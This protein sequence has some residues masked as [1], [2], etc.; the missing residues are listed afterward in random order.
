[1]KL[2][3]SV[4]LGAWFLIGLN[5][6]MA[7]GSIWVFMRMAPAIEVI[8]DR[9]EQ[10]L[11]SCENM[12]SSLALLPPEASAD[13]A[14]QS[15]FAKALESA[16]SNIT[17][18]E[19]PVALESITRNYPKA[20]EGDFAARQRTVSAVIHLADINRRAMVKADRKARQFG[21][22]GAWGVVFMAAAVFLVGLLFI[23]N[24]KKNLVEPLEE[25]HAVSAAFQNG[26]TMRR[27]TGANLPRDIQTVFRFL[28]ELLDKNIPLFF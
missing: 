28:N 5:L 27:C 9:N 24:L 23:H 8:I 11:Q 7:L 19:E 17:E 22:A 4:R 21:N 2:A 3:Q 14:L 6:L 25:I 13:K 10:S 26:D 16:Q 20:F 1:M 15:S 12:L 18:K